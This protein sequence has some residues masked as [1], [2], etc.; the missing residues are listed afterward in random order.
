MNNDYHTFEKPSGQLTTQILL[1]PDEPVIEAKHHEK[2]PVAELAPL[3]T[4]AFSDAITDDDH[5][6]LATE[7]SSMSAKTGA[8]KMVDEAVRENSTQRQRAQDPFSWRKSWIALGVD[9][10]KLGAGVALVYLNAG[11]VRNNSTW[12][13]SVHSCDALSTACSE[14]EKIWLLH[15]GFTSSLSTF[16]PGCSVLYGSVLILDG[17]IGIFADTSKALF[18]NAA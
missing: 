12:E 11:V 9:F 14:Q 6:A 8:E 4:I 7:N 16:L 3:D 5:V 17:V 15:N 18:G 13:Q 10:F 1:R 2:L